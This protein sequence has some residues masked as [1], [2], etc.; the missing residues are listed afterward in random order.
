MAS[1]VF[2]GRVAFYTAFLMDVPFHGN[3]PDTRTVAEVESSLARVIVVSRTS[4][5]DAKLDHHEGFRGLDHVL[6][7][8]E[9]EALESPFKFY[10]NSQYSPDPSR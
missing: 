4:S 8:S 6:F 3:Q 1:T 9:S 5:I 7:D 10:L 2:R